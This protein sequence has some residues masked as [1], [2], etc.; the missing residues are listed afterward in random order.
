ML[1]KQE[2]GKIVKAVKEV[3]KIEGE[4]KRVESFPLTGQMS[5]PGS[6]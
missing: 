2:I 6:W 4:G 5:N 1:C 3:T